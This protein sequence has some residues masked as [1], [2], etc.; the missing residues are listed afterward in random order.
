MAKRKMTPET[1]TALVGIRREVRSLIELLQAKLNR[2]D[3]G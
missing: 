1:R 3:R 2:L